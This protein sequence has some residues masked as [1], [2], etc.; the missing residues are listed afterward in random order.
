MRGWL[1]SVST[2][3][4]INRRSSNWRTRRTVPSKQCNAIEI[5]R[6][7]FISE[8][9]SSPLAVLLS[10]LRILLDAL[11]RS[12]FRACQTARSKRSAARQQRF[13]SASAAR[14]RLSVVPSARPANP[15]WTV[16]DANHA[17]TA[18]MK[19]VIRNVNFSFFQLKNLREHPTSYQYRVKLCD[20]A[21]WRARGSDS[22]QASRK[23][24]TTPYYATQRPWIR[25][26]NS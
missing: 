8:M 13:R 23:H 9:I 21:L 15:V 4:L 18:C 17:M 5:N 25:S 12:L 7:L 20:T 6:K 22:S 19:S 26:I 24:S 10:A 11:L 1:R 14:L 2:T 3:I 16:D